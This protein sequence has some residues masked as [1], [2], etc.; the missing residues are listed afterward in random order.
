[1]ASCVSIELEAEKVPVHQECI[2][3]AGLAGLDPL[4]WA[5]YGGEDYELVGCIDRNS[6]AVLESYGKLNPFH[7]LGFV[8]S[9]TKETELNL[10]NSAAQ[11]RLDDNRLV[12]LDGQKSFQHFE[13]KPN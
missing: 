1:M 12:E 7:V 3:I 11:I 4:D 9:I 2:E 13:N 6:F 5:L 10:S 8:N